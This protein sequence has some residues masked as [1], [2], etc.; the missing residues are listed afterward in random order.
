LRA[1]IRGCLPPCQRQDLHPSKRIVGAAGRPPQLSSRAAQTLVGTRGAGKYF[2]ARRHDDAGLR[3]RMK[4]IAHQR[5]RFSATGACLSAQAGRL[6]DQPQVAVPAVPGRKACGPPPWRS[7]ATRMEDAFE[8][9]FTCR[10]RR[11]LALRHAK[12]SAPTPVAPTANWATRRNC[13]A[14]WPAPTSSKIGWAPCVASPAMWPAK[15]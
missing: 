14:L 8:F 7:Q 2:V 15:R 4:A 13:G 11:N 9:T 5:S 10:P 3:Q 6:R 1:Q 12:S